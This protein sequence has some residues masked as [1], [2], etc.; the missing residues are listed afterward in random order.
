MKLRVKEDGKNLG[1]GWRQSVTQLMPAATYFQTS[2]AKK[3]E[4][5][6]VVTKRNG[7]G[8]GGVEA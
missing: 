3:N 1:L 4:D 8:W 5:P 2:Y 7:G 6:P